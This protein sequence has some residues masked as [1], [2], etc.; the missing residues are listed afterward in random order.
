MPLHALGTA[1]LLRLTGALA[2]LW[3]ASPV[4]VAPAQDVPQVLGCEGPFRRDASQA[5]LAKAFGARNLSTRSIALGEG[6]TETGTVLFATDPT[7][8]IE[9]L[10]TDRKKRSRPRHVTFRT[11]PLKPAA[12][13]AYR[14]R[15]AVPG[16]AASLRLGQPLVEVEAAN[17]RP[18]ELT[19]FDWDYS[20]T[21]TEWRGGVLE[22]PPGGCRI[23][24]RLD[25]EVETGAERQAL[26]GDQV[27]GSDLPAM[28]TVRPRIYEMRLDWD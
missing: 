14:W 8:R 23:L 4:S 7:R 9:I 6:E 25:P 3:L 19:G 12:R 5:S 10:W 22:T 24:V 26:V 17:G 18:F 1:S 15:I 28:R 20:G 13:D 16:G 21:V 11:D 2:G 27:F